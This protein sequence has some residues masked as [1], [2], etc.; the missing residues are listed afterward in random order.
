MLL[1][2]EFKKGTVAKMSEERKHI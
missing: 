1:E 2:T